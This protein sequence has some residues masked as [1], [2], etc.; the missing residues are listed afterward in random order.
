MRGAR[1][2][3]GH[4]VCASEQRVLDLHE[5]GLS[6][7]AISAQLDVSRDYVDKTVTMFGMGTVW[8]AGDSFDAMV[9]AGTGALARA[10]A[11]SGGRFA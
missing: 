3:S 2:P 6:N 7:K 8:R 10:C 4:G 9:R 5:Q 11:A 1:E